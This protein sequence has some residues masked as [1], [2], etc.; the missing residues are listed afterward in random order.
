MV[1]NRKIALSVL[2]IVTSNLLM[3]SLIAC[4][5]E[6]YEF[7]EGGS[8]EGWDWFDDAHTREAKI[9]TAEAMPTSQHLSAVDLEP[10]LPQPSYLPDQL[11]PGKVI[12][13][14]EPNISVNRGN[15]LWGTNIVFH[16]ELPPPVYYVNQLFDVRD[17]N[18]TRGAVTVFIFENVDL[19]KI[20]FEYVT[21]DLSNTQSRTISEGVGEE[22]RVFA[23]HDGQKH[24]AFLRCN[25]F[26]YVWMADVMAEDLA[27][28]ARYLDGNLNDLPC[29][30]SS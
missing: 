6:F 2:V 16:F 19:A 14:F 27:I 22:Y 29:P 5:P 24:I 18:A 26:A 9:A 17:S 13:Q 3:I 4:G 15:E 1:C 7:A 8:S 21:T 28:Y 20:A 23:Y 12:N 10:M 25:A 30:G 11:T